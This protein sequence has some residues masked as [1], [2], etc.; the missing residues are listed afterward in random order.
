MTADP[1]RPRRSVLYVPCDRPR[2]MEK[3]ETLACDA[4]IFDLEDAVA[5]DAKAAARENLRTHFRAFRQSTAERIVRINPLA[6]DFGTEDLLAARGC[7]PDAILLPKVEDDTHLL[8]VSDALA[9]TDAPQT[10]R[11][12]AMI[13]TAR[14]VARAAHLASLSSIGP[15]R[16]GAF[17]VG[18]ND[19]FKETGVNGPDARLYARS[20]LMQVVLGAR[21]GGIAVLDGVFNNHA[22][23]EGL[24]RACAEGA[25]MG[26]DGK[27]L[28]HP[29]QIGA[30]NAAFSPSADSLTAARQ[31]VAAFELPE[32][33]G[34]G[35]IALDG[36]MVERLHFQ[37]A[38]ALL[39]KAVAIAARETDN[40]RDTN[41][42]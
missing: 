10:L 18:T 22:D 31:I 39:A 19:L 2:A 1:I 12:W 13:E 27:T 5:P 33:A 15:Y 7:R 36:R 23:L 21:S 6:S 42:S 41:P 9:Q 38:Q 37:Q 34:K 3:A 35:V 32:N 8:D 24:A 17:V 20:W 30:A 26:F 4:I 28:I 11:L 25:A 14:G 16:L 29:V 40:N